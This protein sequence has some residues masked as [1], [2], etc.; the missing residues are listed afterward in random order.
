MTNLSRLALLYATPADD[1]RRQ[2]P[3]VA[4]GLSAALATLSRAPTP[5]AAELAAIRL[6]GAKGLCLRLSAALQREA[7]DH[8]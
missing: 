1:L 4:D 8:A 5:D 7:R 6:E 2:L 3:E